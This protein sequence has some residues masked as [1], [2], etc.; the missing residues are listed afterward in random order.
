MLSIIL[1]QLV[2]GL[3]ERPK[4][5]S[6]LSKIL[7]KYE[8]KGQWTSQKKEQQQFQY[9]TVEQGDAYMIF[10]SNSTQQN[11]NDLI[12]R[13]EFQLLNPIYPE[14]RQVL[15]IFQLT[16]YSD[17]DISFENISV[18]NY[19]TAYKFRRTHNSKENCE[20]AYTV[21]I[22]FES[23]IYDEKHTKIKVHL[24]T[25]NNSLDLSCD[26]DIEMDLTLDTTNYLL[27]I[28]MYCTMSVMICF[29]QFLFV[30]KLCKALIENLED[31]N[32]LV[33]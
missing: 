10:L 23:E 28:I 13:L 11:K 7:Q 6:E 33:I 20:I 25:H 27:R 16:N 31:S 15:G 8:Y 3:S 17:S 24:Y 26:V 2:I 32:K 22:E 1:F 12:D 5:I 29:T 30:T 21:N 9:M 4:N 19:S 18:L 14:K